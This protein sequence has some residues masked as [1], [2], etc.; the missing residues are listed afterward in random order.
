MIALY[1][2][3]RFKSKIF[4][5]FP[6]WLVYSISDLLTPV[7]YY[8][9]TYRK[10]VIVQNLQNSFPNKS[11][12]EI[13]DLTYRFY[14]SLID[15]SFETIKMEHM[16]PTKYAQRITVENE[17]IL[18]EI[19]DNKQG[20]VVVMSHT[21]NW[22]WICQRIA[23]ESNYFEEIGVIAKEMSNPY[24]E[25]YFRFLRLRI[26]S[27]KVIMVPFLQ[28]ARFVSSG[29]HKSKMIVAIA[30]QTPHKNQISF[31]A[32]FLNQ[33][34]PVFLGPEKIAKTLDYKVLF[35]HATRSGRGKYKIRFEPISFQ[36]KLEDEYFITNSHLKMLEA[37]I[38][39]QPES[40]LWSHRRW[41]Y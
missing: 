26:Q 16:T 10:K 39:E 36:A 12:A 31:R 15:I 37:D 17:N 25:K 40:W 19:A 7:L 21:G 18:K 22:E 2:I 8:I 11:P 35:C 3:F 4:S 30:D 14:K 29:R 32:P 9:F 5:L 27:K 6:F 23:L 1:W 13:R 20:V 24:F 34:T 38:I 41:K 28:S 33:D